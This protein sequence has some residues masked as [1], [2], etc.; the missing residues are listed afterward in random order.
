VH[1]PSRPSDRG[2][3]PAYD[4]SLRFADCDVITDDKELD[5]V[6]FLGVQ[7]GVLFL[8]ETEV[9]DVAS[10]V[11]K[12]DGTYQYAAKTPGIQA[13][14]S[15]HDDHSTVRRIIIISAKDMRE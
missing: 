3:P 7:R 4:L 2:A 8:C 10:V 14:Y 11:S 9:E 13:N 15:L 6:R 12:R 1:R 5:A